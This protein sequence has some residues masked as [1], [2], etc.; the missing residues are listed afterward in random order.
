V[1][2]GMGGAKLLAERG[3]EPPIYTYD[4][5]PGGPPVGIVRFLGHELPPGEPLPDHAHAHDFLVLT[6]FAQGGGDLRLQG[7][8]WQIRPGD[9]YLIAPGQVVGAGDDRTALTLAEGWGVY[10]PPEVLASK[11]P[12]GFESWRAHPL[13]FPFV[14]GVAGGAQRLSVPARERPAWSERMTALQDELEQRRDGYREAALAHLTLLLVA[15]SRLAADVVGDLRLRREPMLADV[16]D[17]IERRYCEPISLKEVAGEVGVS[18]GHLTTVVRRKTGRTVGA[19]VTERRMAQARMLL[20]QTDLP[21]NDIARRVGY[22]D[23]AYFARC[24]RRAHGVPP[25]NWRRAG[26]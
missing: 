16:F 17:V 7:H 24:F 12:G 4:Q 6:Y 25:L 22:D 13:L 15:V 26:I 19:W 5:V 14:Q 10:F 18:A 20:V 8:R 23:P 21:V 3:H 1:V 2:N 11:T 9:V